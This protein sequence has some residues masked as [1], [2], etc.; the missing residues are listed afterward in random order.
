MPLT[1]TISCLPL[2]VETICQY[3]G[4]GFHEIISERGSVR[5]IAID[6]L[7]RFGGL[8]GAEVG[9]MMSIDY[10]TVSQGRK[11]LSEKLKKDKKLSAIMKKIESDLS[12]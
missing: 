7:Y 2:F 9:G 6:M 12:I 4:R 10:S 1:S 8:K 5:Q 11:R 3:V